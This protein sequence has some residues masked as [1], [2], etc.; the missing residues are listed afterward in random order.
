MRQVE[1]MYGPDWIMRLYFEVPR[2]SSNFKRLCQLACSNPNFELCDA[3]TNPR[4]GNMHK[5]YPLVWR[6]F[7]VLDPYVDVLLVRDLDSHLSLRE[8]NAVTEFMQSEK[9]FHIM[10][11]HKHHG[12]VIMGGT[13]GVKLGHQAV[14]EQFKQSI[15][16]FFTDKSLMFAKRGIAGP[17]QTALARHVWP[18]AR[19]VALAHDSFLCKKFSSTSPFPSKRPE[20]VGNF[21]GAV[22]SINNT[23]EFT[24]E[25]QCPV[26][27]RPKLHKDW[28]YC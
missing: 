8:V 16:K 17:D 13:W 24:S 27:C 28:L 23:I 20:G 22:I 4:F 14:R 25:N 6:F 11:D 10:R 15:A 9:Q 1:P 12:S 5:I 26:K 18:W 7:P 2:N 19:Q 3:T 21:V